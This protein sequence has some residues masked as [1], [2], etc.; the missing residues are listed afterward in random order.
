MPA[1]VAGFRSGSAPPAP[2][3]TIRAAHRC[4]RMKEYTMTRNSGPWTVE[5]IAKLKGEVE[6]RL[7][8]LR[9][10]LSEESHK[11]VSNLV[12][13]ARFDETALGQ[14]ANMWQPSKRSS[15][16]CPSSTV[17]SFARRPTRSIANCLRLVSDS[18]RLGQKLPRLGATFTRLSA[19]S[20]PLTLLGKLIS[21]T[22][23]GVRLRS[24]LPHSALNTQDSSARS[25]FLEQRRSRVTASVDESVADNDDMDNDEV[26]LPSA[27]V[28]RP[29]TPVPV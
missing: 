8:E 21:A 11:L 3:R 1:S 15:C 4:G 7:T 19:P 22:A 20:R 14:I 24:P 18:Q 12:Q 27:G 2:A 25:Q 9:C 13:S 28:R 5:N 16:C 29:G 17:R 26:A 23:A 6:R 10:R